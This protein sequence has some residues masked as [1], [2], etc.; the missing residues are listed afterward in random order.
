MCTRDRDAGEEKGCDQGVIIAVNT[1]IKLQKMVGGVNSDLTCHLSSTC[2]LSPPLFLCVSVC[3]YM[4]LCATYTLVC[5]LMCAHVK[6][7]D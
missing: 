6:V 1:E 7:S 4:S 3:L 2:F 5:V